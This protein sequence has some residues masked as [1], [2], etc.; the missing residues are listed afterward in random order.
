MENLSKLSRAED[1]YKNIS[2]VHDMTLKERD[3]LKELVEQ[4]KTKQQNEAGESGE[5][6]Y[7]VRGHPGFFQIVK[8]RRHY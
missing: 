1:S 7:R 5:W 6:N 8:I 2:I 4:A 3:E